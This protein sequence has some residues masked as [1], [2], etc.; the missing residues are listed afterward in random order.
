MKDHATTN[1]PESKIQSK[2]DA[3]DDLKVFDSI[4]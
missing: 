2:P 4:I 1:K 3:K